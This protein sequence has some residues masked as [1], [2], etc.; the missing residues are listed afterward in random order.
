MSFFN[1]TDLG[2]NTGFL[3]YWTFSNLPLFILAAP[4]LCILTSSGIWLY[5]QN[6]T[7]SGRYLARRKLKAGEGPEGLTSNSEASLRTTKDPI[8]RLAVPQLVLAVM[9]FMIY[10]VQIITRLSSGYPV[11][12]WWVASLIEK[13]TVWPAYSITWEPGKWIVRYMV[14]YA[15]I[16]AGLFASFLPPA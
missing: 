15:I 8:W 7:I 11:W 16:Q 3:K 14:I 6:V 10:H 9:A 2:R 1:K 4:M 5:H 12:Y 13:N